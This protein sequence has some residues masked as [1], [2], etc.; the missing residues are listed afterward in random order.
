MSEY[1]D[2][3]TQNQRVNNVGVHIDASRVLIT[4]KTKGKLNIATIS[5]SDEDG[6]G[7]LIFNSNK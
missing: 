6:C 2:F 5:G 3:C 1:S 4:F 7:L